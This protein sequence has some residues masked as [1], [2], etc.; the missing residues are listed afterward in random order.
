MIQMEHKL[1][2]NKQYVAGLDVILVSRHIHQYLR[3]RKK[4]LTLVQE[5]YR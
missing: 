1:D 5:N 4:Y 3:Y 2:M